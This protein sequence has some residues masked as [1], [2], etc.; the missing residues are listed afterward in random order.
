[1][2]QEFP[3]NS[4]RSKAP[5]IEAP[6]EK[7]VERVVQGEVIRRKK[8]LGRRMN[9][10]FF[11]GNPKEAAHR[12]F[13]EVV[14]PGAKDL[15]FDG[16][17]TI[18]REVMFRGEGGARAYRGRSV[19]GSVG[20]GNMAYNAISTMRDDPR[21][22]VSRARALHNFDEIII[23]SRMEAEEILDRLLGYIERY[24]QVTVADL[25]D[26]AGAGSTHTDRAHGWTDLTPARVVR[27]GSMGYRLDLPKPEPLGR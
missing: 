12:A 17:M 5:E 21:G 7:V 10:F 6:K 14:R 2:S 26:M 27:V 1:M 13:D 25:Y 15:I 3:S 4:H 9:D 24:E 8:P 18:L 16:A 11:G 23:P 22:Q 19:L 20:I